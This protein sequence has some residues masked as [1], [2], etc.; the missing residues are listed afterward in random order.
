MVSSSPPFDEVFHDFHR[1]FKN[2]TND[3]E[4]QSIVVTSG[5]WDLGNIFVEQ[6]KLFP[7]TI[8]IPEFMCSWINI[9]K[10]NCYFNFI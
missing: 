8:Q 4:E 2:N 9:K 10:V 7:S 5:N 6:C 3:G 1:W